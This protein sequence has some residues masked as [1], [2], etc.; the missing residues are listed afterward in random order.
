MVKLMNNLHLFWEVVDARITAF[1][2]PNQLQLEVFDIGHLRRL[3]MRWKVLMQIILYSQMT[4]S[5][6]IRK[7]HFDFVKRLSI[8]K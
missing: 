8:V 7:K 6:L 3:W 5:L 2:A 1:F 4:L